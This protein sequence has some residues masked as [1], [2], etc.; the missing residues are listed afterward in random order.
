[1]VRTKILKPTIFF[2]FIKKKSNHFGAKIMAGLIRQPK[3]GH[4]KE[5]HRAIKMCEPALVSA[6]P[7][8][9]SL[10]NFQ[11]VYFFSWKSII[12][13]GHS[14]TGTPEKKNIYLFSFPI[15]RLMYILPN[16]E[17]ARLFCRTTTRTRPR[18][19]CSTTCITICLRGPSAFSPTVETWFS[20]PPR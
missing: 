13:S 1:M 19:W 2:L 9:T 7:I 10:G 6:D 3:Y 17:S 18:E 12:Q 4:L 15:S 16:P 20:I 11:Q 5:L 8:I 14:F